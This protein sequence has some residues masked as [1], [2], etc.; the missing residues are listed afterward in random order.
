MAIQG[1]SGNPLALPADQIWLEELIDASI[2]RSIAMEE[3][4]ACDGSPGRRLGIARVFRIA[5]H[6]AELEAW[7][8]Y[9]DA[10][11]RLPGSHFMPQPVA[12]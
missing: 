5:A 8:Q 9:C 11:A 3:W 1:H 4:L 7:Q 12:A 6:R 2:A 10:R